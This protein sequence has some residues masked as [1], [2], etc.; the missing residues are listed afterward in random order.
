MVTQKLVTRVELEVQILNHGNDYYNI[1]FFS[2]SHKESLSSSY[3][4]KGME[5]G[6]SVIG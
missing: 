5:L 6:A 3:V 1:L 4:N 2:S